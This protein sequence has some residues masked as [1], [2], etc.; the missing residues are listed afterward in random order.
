MG[1]VPIKTEAVE[2]VV[3]KS[4]EKKIISVDVGAAK[5]RFG[6]K[7]TSMRKSALTK[8]ANVGVA[9][10]QKQINLLSKLRDRAAQ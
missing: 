10:T 9:I 8:F 6:N 5:E 7:F 1:T 2:V 4:A 3:M